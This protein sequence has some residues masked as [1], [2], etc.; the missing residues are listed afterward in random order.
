MQITNN[1]DALTEMHDITNS[2]GCFVV[3]PNDVLSVE[4]EEFMKGLMNNEGHLIGDFVVWEEVVTSTI[5]GK[6]TIKQ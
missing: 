6:K 3:L 5:D 4:K 1:M 2:E